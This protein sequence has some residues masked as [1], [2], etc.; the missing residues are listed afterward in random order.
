M[1]FQCG[2]GILLRTSLWEVQR[3]RW[4]MGLTS[5]G[6]TRK[7]ANTRAFFGVSDVVAPQCVL[8]GRGLGYVG[9]SRKAL[10]RAPFRPAC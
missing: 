2:S 4:L 8:Q 5:L 10:E 3:A 6:D 9:S 1:R 7:H